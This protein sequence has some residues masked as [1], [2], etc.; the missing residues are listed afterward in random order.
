MTNLFEK[1]KSPNHEEGLQ[2]H[3]DWHDSGIKYYHSSIILNYYNYTKQSFSLLCTSIEKLLKIYLILL[4]KT[5]KEK[6]KNDYFHNLNKM[7]KDSKLDNKKFTK[8]FMLCEKLKYNQ[9]RYNYELIGNLS[10]NWIK[11]IH[12]EINNLSEIIMKTIN[13]KFKVNY[14]CTRA[15]DI[16]NR[17]AKRI[18]NKAIKTI[19][20]QRI[21]LT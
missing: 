9:I 20:N 8:I 16:L 13:E 5:T 14:R 3:I 17:K 21:E 2:E 19:P 11:D 18:V 7:L 12:L 6:V 1:E 10:T 15:N 4:G